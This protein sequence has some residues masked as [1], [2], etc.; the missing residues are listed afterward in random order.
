MPPG[1]PLIAGL[2]A[3][4]SLDNARYRAEGTGL[5]A[6]WG[7]ARRAFGAGPPATPCNIQDP[8]ADPPRDSVPTP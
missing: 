3:T 6:W 4:V 8:T 2:T 7:I 1:V 5:Q